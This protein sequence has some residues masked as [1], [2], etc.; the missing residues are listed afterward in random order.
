MSPA[1]SF[2]CIVPA[3][4]ELHAKTAACHQLVLEHYDR[5][6]KPLV[7]YVTSLG[8]E[9]DIA[10]EIVQDTFVKLHEHLLNSGSQVNLRSW[11]YRVAHNLARNMQS[12]VRNRRTGSL[13]D[14]IATIDPVEA[15][16]SAEANLIAKQE[17]LR[18]SQAM[19]ALRPAQRNCLVL[20]AQGLKYK[21]IAEV[22]SLSVSAVAENVQRGL[23]SLKESL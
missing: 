6:Q 12:S 16:L 14:V 23:L 22:L 18:M 8:I 11:L 10:G 3:W 17:K 4:D 15:G 9:N 20:R 21:E 1:R 5:E 13:E 19:D 7:R 2:P